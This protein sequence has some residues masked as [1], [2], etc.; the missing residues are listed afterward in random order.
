[1]IKPH[2]SAIPERMD[3]FGIIGGEHDVAVLLKVERV[4]ASTDIIRRVCNGASL[5]FIDDVLAD[6]YKGGL[7]W[8]NRCG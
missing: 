7:L 2:N 6:L 5:S 4:A 8:C 3:W 1:M